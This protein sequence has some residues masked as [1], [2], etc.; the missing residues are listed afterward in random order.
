MQGQGGAQPPVPRGKAASASAAACSPGRIRGSH[1]RSPPL[2]SADLLRAVAQASC[3]DNSRGRAR[4]G[5]WRSWIASGSVVSSA[6]RFS[7][8]IPLEFHRGQAVR[9]VRGWAEGQLFPREQFEIVIA[10]PVGHPTAE[11][12]EIRGLLGPQDRCWSSIVTTTWTSARRQPRARAAKCCSSRSRTACRSPGRL[13]RDAVA[14][15]NR[16]GPDSAAGRSRSPAT[17]CRRSRRSGTGRESSSACMSIP[18]GRCSTMLRRASVG[19]LPGGRLR[20]GLRALRRMAHR[21][22][23]LRARSEDRLRA[24]VRSTTYP[25]EFGGWRRFTADFVQGQMAYSGSSPRST[26]DDVR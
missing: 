11:L 12:D 23:L 14:R 16:S 7:V 15:E 10:A 5:R 2:V 4:T 24:D 25:G 1:R 19:V 17:S 20:S 13:P 22:P 26:R 9:C 8:I 6:L 18:G 21:R 3:S